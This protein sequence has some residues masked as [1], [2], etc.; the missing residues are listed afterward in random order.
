MQS[1]A[2]MH[3][4]GVWARAYIHLVKEEKCEYANERQVEPWFTEKYSIAQRLC[5]EEKATNT[6]NKPN[7]GHAQLS[8]YT[9]DNIRH[10]II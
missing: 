1:D 5:S 3:K 6:M 7:H 8:E 9:I 2:A 4:H 10:N